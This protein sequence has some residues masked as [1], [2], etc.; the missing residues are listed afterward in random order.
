MEGKEAYSW[1]EFVSL[2]IYIFT[3]SYGIHQNKL[4]LYHG[5]VSN[6]ISWI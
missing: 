2:F 6:H 4:F 5:E 1:N 3:G